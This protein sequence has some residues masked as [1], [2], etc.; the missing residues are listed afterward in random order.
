MF[1]ICEFTNICVRSGSSS[2]I[3]VI[4]DNSIE[5]LHSHQSSEVG[6]QVDVDAGSKASL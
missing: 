2:D 1:N 6:R 5:V 3:S 4:S